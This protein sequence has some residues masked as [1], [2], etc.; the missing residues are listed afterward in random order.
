MEKYCESLQNA[1]FE[2]VLEAFRRGLRSEPAADDEEAMKRIVDLVFQ[3]EAAAGYSVQELDGLIRKLFCKTRCRLGILQPLMEDPSVTEIMVNGPQH[4]FIERDGR[5]ERW[6]MAFD[7]QEELED[8]M[9]NIAAQVHREI[10][11]MQPIVDARL[12]DGSRV[13]GVYRNV[14]VNGPIL[15]IRKFSENFLTLKSLIGSGTVT[16]AGAQL[17][18][19]LVE[20]GY[21]IFVSGGTSS[22]KTT[23]LNALSEYIPA[24]ERVIVI[25]DSSELKLT[26][27]ENIV[28]LE[29]RNSNAAGK[30]QITMSQLLK[31]SLRMRPDRIIVGEVR[32]SEVLDMLQALNTGHSGMSTG[33]GN[34]V[35][36]MLRRLETMYMM[37][38]PLHIEAVRAQIAE[39]LDIMVHVEKLEGGRRRVVEITEIEGFEHG[40]FQLNPLLKRQ[41]G[42]MLSPTGNLLK[43]NRKVIWKGEQYV[44]K[45]R[46][47][48]FLPA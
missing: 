18:A 6:P 27:V 43:R 4:I 25:E 30:G 33:H 28:H 13:N 44:Q 9:R 41:D 17:L 47:L 12:E 15:T 48:G 26:G 45:L 14:A 7:S 29:C 16:E 32:G 10:N 23:F 38:M 37:A 31:S 39:A 24:G 8:I 36:G 46:N 34:S 3:D 22:G 40:K 2:R 20:C 5:M 19:C 11:E 42:G 21:N 35:E 1:F